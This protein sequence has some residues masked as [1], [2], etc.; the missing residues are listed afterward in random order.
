MAW[1]PGIHTASRP[2]IVK[3]LLAWLKDE[4]N[5]GQR[6]ADALEWAKDT[7]GFSGQVP[8]FVDIFNSSGGR[9]KDAFPLLAL[10]RR[11]TEPSAEDN[12]SVQV[13]HRLRFQMW[14]ADADAEQLTEKGEVYGLA[15]S[16]MLWACPPGT[17]LAG[18]PTRGNP[19][20]DVTTIDGDETRGPGAPFVQLPFVEMTVKLL[21]VR[22]DG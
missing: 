7:L 22:S 13:A 4:E 18:C 10:V 17:L 2:F 16:S 3:N 14:L 15:L 21:E 19:T 20:I 11:M 6:Q 8:K 1:T 9:K 12:Y 5:D